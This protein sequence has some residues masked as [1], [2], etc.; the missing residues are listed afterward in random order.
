MQSTVQHALDRPSQMC[1]QPG[2]WSDQEILLLLGGLE[3]HKDCGADIAD[4]VGT[5]SQVQ[6]ILH[7]LQLP[8]EDEYL[9]ELEDRGHKPQGVE[10]PGENDTKQNGKASQEELIPFADTGN[11]ILSQ[12]T[13]KAPL[14]DRYCV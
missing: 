10:G 5:K 2:E 3:L 4:H 12:V 11:P 7:F 9:D 1:V 14:S 6:C 13:Y 8:I